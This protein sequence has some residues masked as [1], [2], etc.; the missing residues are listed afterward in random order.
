MKA[1]IIGHGKMAK[2]F[3]KRLLQDSWEVIGF[4]ESKTLGD[5]SLWWQDIV[6]LHVGSGKQLRD[7][8]TICERGRIPMLNGSTG[9]QLPEVC[10]MPL[11]NATNFALPILRLLH[12]LPAM[13]R[14][15][16]CPEFTMNRYIAESHPS[17]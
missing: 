5:A 3:T 10:G 17:S 4:D 13:A 11:V 15:L 2:L 7:A 6:A 12:L 1:L 9:Q 8:L 16:D 14:E